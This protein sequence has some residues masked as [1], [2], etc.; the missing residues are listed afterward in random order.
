MGK[1][2]LLL[3][4]VLPFLGYS[5][6]VPFHHIVEREHSETVKLQAPWFTG[7]LFA[8][9]SFTVPPGH[10]NFEPYIFATANT[11][12]YGH[13][14]ESTKTPTYWN[15]YFQPAFQTGVTK[16]IDFEIEPTLFYNYTNGAGKWVFG[17]MPILLD[18][19]L[20]KQGVNATDWIMGLKFSLRETIP[21]G[22]YQ[23]LN[24]KKKLTDIGGQGSWQTAFALVWGNLFYLGGQVHFLAWRTEIQYNLP[25]PVH[26]K[27]LNAYGGGKGTD[28][29]VYPP[30]NFMIDTAI[31]INL[32]RNWVF[33][34]DFI[35]SWSGKT[36]FK[37]KTVVPMTAPPSAQ[38]SLAPAIEYNWSTNLGIILGPWFT[39]A[40]RNTVQ[41]ASGVFAVNYFY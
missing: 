17:D 39:I 25:A 13:N 14:W 19:Q 18:F 7:P 30:Q 9:S 2:F 4:L 40:G 1:R 36:R 5:D 20:Y 37:G 6:K 28:G 11:G 41:F 21:L 24:P 35:G 31:E 3:L 16:W 38:F 32:S 23:N 26:V 12:H 27:N 33:A 15:T 8:S 34:M 10:L 29:T 22:K